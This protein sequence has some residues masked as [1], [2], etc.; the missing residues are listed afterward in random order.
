MTALDSWVGRSLANR[1][2]NI[3]ADYYSMERRMWL[4]FYLNMVM[5]ALVAD[6]RICFYALLSHVV[7]KC[8]LFRK[9]KSNKCLASLQI[10]HRANARSICGILWPTVS[11]EGLK[12]QEN[13][14]YSKRDSAI[15][16]TVTTIALT[17]P[18]ERQTRICTHTPS[19]RTLRRFSWVF[20]FSV[21]GCSL[22]LCVTHLP[23]IEVI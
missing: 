10:E 6:L 5:Y 21:F 16:T 17:R 15:A 8:F 18:H 12:L 19:A 4:R 14:L 23:F 2:H 20:F 13:C 22:C 1:F 11:L 3:I 9:A 7:R